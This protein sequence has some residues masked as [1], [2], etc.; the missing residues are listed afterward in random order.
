MDV[1]ADLYDFLKE[2]KTELK[3][4]GDRVIAYVY[5]NF[6]DLNRFI[7]IIGQEHFEES[8][9]NCTLNVT[10]I[11]IEITSILEF[12]EHELS[13][14]RN[15]FKEWEIY[16]QRILRMDGYTNIN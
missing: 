8:G 1:N 15:C 9:L 14:Y 13:N 5:I 7:R 4:A 16:K 3:E 12:E 11:C 10:Q 6:S 2:N